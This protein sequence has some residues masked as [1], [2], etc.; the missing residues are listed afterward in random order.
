V[1]KQPG[2]PEKPLSDLGRHSFLFYFPSPNSWNLK[3]TCTLYSSHR[4]LLRYENERPELIF[5]NKKKHILKN[6]LC[7]KMLLRELSCIGSFAISWSGP[8]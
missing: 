6:N 2:T 4:Q 5:S 3:Y 1:E 8:L 7:P